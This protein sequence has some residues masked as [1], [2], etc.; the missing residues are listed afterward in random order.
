MA[1]SA[2]STPHLLTVRVRLLVQEEPR[3]QH[4]SAR[5]ASCPQTG[6]VPAPARRAASSM[7]GHA[8][9]AG[10]RLTT[11]AEEEASAS[12]SHA[13]QQVQEGPRQ[14]V[15]LIKP[16]GGAAASPTGAPG[17]RWTARGPMAAAAGAAPAQAGVPAAPWL[18]QVGE[19][20]LNMPKPKPRPKKGAGWSADPPPALARRE[21]APASRSPAPGPAHAAV[22]LH[23]QAGAA[24]ARSALE[25]KALRCPITRVSA[26]RH[27]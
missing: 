16:T 14:P 26:G 12:P 23:E 4:A 9:G 2:R 13:E 27:T 7:R 19:V 22:P 15:P 18:A 17:A 21:A 8:S 5:L 3:Q 10:A 1:G 20:P 25:L 6:E 11:I 24:A